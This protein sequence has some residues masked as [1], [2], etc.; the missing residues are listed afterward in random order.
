MTVELEIQNSLNFDLVKG[1]EQRNN[2]FLSLDLKEAIAFSENIYMNQLNDI[3][4]QE[5]NHV[6]FLGKYTDFLNKEDPKLSMS[7]TVIEDSLN[8]VYLDKQINE[9]EFKPNHTPFKF[10]W[11]YVPNLDDTF[12]GMIKQNDYYI[13]LNAEDKS[14]IGNVYASNSN[15]SPDGVNYIFM[16]FIG[17]IFNPKPYK[18]SEI[19][20][21][22]QKH[23]LKLSDK[24]VSHLLNHNK[25]FG[26]DIEGNKKI[27]H[28]N[29]NGK[30]NLYKYLSKPF[31][32]NENNKFDLEKYRKPLM[33]FWEKKLLEEATP[34]DF[35]ENELVKE[36]I[37]VDSENFLNGFMKIGTVENYQF[38]FSQDKTDLVLEIYL[39]LNG[40]KELEGT[41]WIYQLSHPLNGILGDSTYLPIRKMMKIGDI[42][43]YLQ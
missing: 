29:L 13:V 2:F 15:K 27:Y 12:N 9:L 20:G 7:N 28:L 5:Y 4:N 3:K 34:E 19:A 40:P 37:K 32:K 17:H 6:S 21:F 36:Q 35:A 10:P 25:F 11:K 43:T 42:Y 33:D 24:L 8:F 26:L 31:D 22:E 14:K 23:N 1:F 16:V 30:D 41:V 39:L 18:E 38:K